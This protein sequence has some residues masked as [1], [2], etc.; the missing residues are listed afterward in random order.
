MK[1][2]P[3]TVAFGHVDTTPSAAFR[4]ELRDQF[5]GSLQPGAGDLIPRP[6]DDDMVKVVESRRP[7]GR[8]WK[9]VVGAAASIALVAGLATIIVT[10]RS[11]PNGV[12]TRRDPAIAELALIDPDQLGP[13]WGISRQFSQ[14]TSRRVAEVAAGIPAC[15][16]YL[17][18][19]FDSPG[20]KA[21]TGGRIFQGPTDAVLTQ[22]VYIFPT[23]VAAS[24]AMDKIAE[25][26]FV[27]CFN[28]FMG[29]LLA[30]LVGNPTFA[31][32]VAVPSPAAHGDRQVVLGQ[33]VRIG[34]GLGK[35]VLVNAFVQV[36]RGIVYVDPTL[37]VGSA[38]PTAGVEKALAEATIA[39]TKA[40]DTAGG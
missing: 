37:D 36:G 1:R 33:S 26:A 29:A 19:A 39:L 40:L 2:H 25:S 14:L 20:R 16:P 38:N 9:V 15:G 30:G 22:W 13:D 8:R 24:R 27:P 21:V 10:H 18:S 4:D 31:T 3:I 35:S 28:D 6:S 7:S 5:V 11:E 12:D 32:T 17:D 23:E 34:G